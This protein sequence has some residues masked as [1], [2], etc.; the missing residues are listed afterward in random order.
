MKLSFKVSQFNELTWLGFTFGVVSFA[1]TIVS[2]SFAI[3]SSTLEFWRW[4]RLH[5]Q[6]LVNL[7]E[8]Q[9]TQSVLIILKNTSDIVG[10]QE[11]FKTYLCTGSDIFSLLKSQITGSI[12]WLLLTRIK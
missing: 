7:T 11:S 3:K 2:S 12:G 10:S 4:Q 9:Q 5:S 1:I 6:N 8:S